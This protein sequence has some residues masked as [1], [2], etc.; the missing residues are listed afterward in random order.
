MTEHDWRVRVDDIL[1]AI[2]KIQRYLE[3]MSRETFAAD[4]RTADAVVR[5]L[6]VIGEAARYMPPAVETRFPSI[7]WA[8]M[9][10]LR[11]VVVH[12]YA[13]VDLDIVWETCQSDLPPLV[14]L[15][16]ELLSAGA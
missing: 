1:E 9:R 7:P 6:I 5:N 14:P 4:G 11:N 8:K 3:G 2:Q 13:G 15:L 12:D 16:H 10:G